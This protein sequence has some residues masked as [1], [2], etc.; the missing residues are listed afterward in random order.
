[1][2][3]RKIKTIRL[4]IVVLI[5]ISLISILVLSAKYF[6]NNDDYSFDY[7]S[8]NINEI[9]YDDYEEFDF[10]LYSKSYLLMRLNDFKVLY[11]KNIDDIF[12][13]ASLT[14]V[15]T[16][17]TVVSEF[18]DYDDVSSFSYDDYV[19]LINE[20]ASLAYLDSDT[21]YSIEELLYGLILPSGAD[22]GAALD[23]YFNTHD[24]DLVEQMNK[25]V[26]SLGLT[27][28]HFT[29]YAGL[30]DD[31]LYT[32]LNDYSQIVLDTLLNDCA[33]KVLKTFDYYLEDG[34]HLYSTLRVL[35][36]DDEII[37][38]GGKTGFT[39]EAGENI[40]ILYKYKNRSYMLI[41]A[42]APGNPYI[43]QRYHFD[44]V[45][46]IFNNLYN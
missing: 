29:N 12:Y 17:D 33:K 5:P 38:Y 20:N 8:L 18:D 21:D 6:I 1:M 11:G 10:S 36:R 30:H 27:N 14:K 43:G 31:E 23:N 19:R 13:P 28:S 44:D 3:K 46:K 22:A 24:L 9:N 42:N 4:L 26:K 32:S 39:D 45:N 41:L 16:L 2:K 25:K 37:T 34:T 7:K 15:L 40:L 35:E